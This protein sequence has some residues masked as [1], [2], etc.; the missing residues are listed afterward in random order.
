MDNLA[1]VAPRTQLRKKF[2]KIEIMVTESFLKQ[3]YIA[4]RSM[5]INEATLF[6]GID[7]FSRSLSSKPMDMDPERIGS[8]NAFRDIDT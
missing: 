4:L 6:P 5:N 1:A 3:A 2:V 8:E 7:G